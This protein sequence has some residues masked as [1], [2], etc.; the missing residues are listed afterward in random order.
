MYRCSVSSSSSIKVS[1]SLDGCWCSSGALKVIFSVVQTLLDCL[2]EHTFCFIVSTNNLDARF[3][4]QRHRHPCDWT[5]YLWNFCK[6]I[7]SLSFLHF[8]LPLQLSC[9]CCF[10]DKLK[11]VCTFYNKTHKTYD[12]VSLLRS[13]HVWHLLLLWPLHLLVSNHL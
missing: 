12:A 7:L 4:R 5:A 6:S 8:Y 9:C 13:V 3:S 11:H 1:L 2:A 10:S